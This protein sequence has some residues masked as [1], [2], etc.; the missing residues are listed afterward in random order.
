[1]ALRM[2]TGEDGSTEGARRIRALRDNA[3]YFRARLTE[4]GFMLLGQYDS[5]VVPIFLGNP[6]SIGSFSRE[7][8][9]RS[10]AV[11]V[12][13]FPATPLTGARVRICLSAAHTRAELDRAIEVLTE[14]A[15]VT[16]WRAHQQNFIRKHPDQWALMQKELKRLTATGDAAKLNGHHKTS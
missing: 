4:R 14:V 13:G 7:C 3:V 10:L 2:L 16:T 1:V 5:P 15:D 11:V 9:R 6:N 8:L 12:V